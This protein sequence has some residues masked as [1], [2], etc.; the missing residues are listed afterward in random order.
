MTLGQPYSLL[1]LHQRTMEILGLRVS[2]GSNQQ[3]LAR[4]ALEQIGAAHYLGDLHCLIVGYNSQL[5]RRYVIAPPNQKIGEVFSGNELLF[6][7]AQVME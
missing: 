4:G 1:I 2:Q 6:T 5:I 7:K 3:Q